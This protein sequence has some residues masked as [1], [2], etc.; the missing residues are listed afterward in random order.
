MLRMKVV[1]LA[2]RVVLQAGVAIPRVSELRQQIAPYESR[3]AT[4]FA[5]WPIWQ[6]DA[7]SITNHKGY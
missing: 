5:L 6:L 7:P 2:A 1:P 4:I 3:Q